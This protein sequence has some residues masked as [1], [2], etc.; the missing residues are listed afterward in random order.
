MPSTLTPKET[1]VIGAVI[2][3]TFAVEYAL[4][5]GPLVSL[6]LVVFVVLAGTVALVPG[7]RDT[8]YRKTGIGP[9]A[10]FLAAAVAGAGVGLS[11]LVGDPRPFCE[12]L[13][14]IRGCLTPFGWS[15][16][17]YVAS[18]FGVAVGAGHLGRYRRARA[19]RAVPA[20]DVDPGLVS[21]EGTIEPAGPT[22]EGPVSGEETVWYRRALER[23][24]L[25]GG[26]REVEQ[27]TDGV[28]FYVED[29]S[30]RLL[31]LPDSVDVHA[32]AE[33]ARAHRE[34]ADGGRRREWSYRPGDPVT[35]VGEAREVS[36]AAYPEPV[37][38]GLD[39]PVVLSRPTLDDLRLWA[40]RRAVLGPTIAV[41]VGGGSLLGMLLT[42]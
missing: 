30:G 28:R 13:A 16:A 14:G 27:G 15:A 4:P 11:Y 42:A 9:G 36:R 1:L 24:T 33:F 22:L 40:A 7:A 2:A 21:V 37:A 38:V 5:V 10:W 32:A 39:G 20:A 8:L 18:T 29:G 35:V 12:G 25:F 41:V 31:V 3:G 34:D 19:A 17:L 6:L 23:P 26:H